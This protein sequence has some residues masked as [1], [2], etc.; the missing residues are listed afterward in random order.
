LRTAIDLG[1]MRIRSRSPSANQSSFSK[2]SARISEKG[3]IKAKRAPAHAQPGRE[4][5]KK[6][7]IGNPKGRVLVCV[8][9]RPLNKVEVKSREPVA[10]KLGRQTVTDVL[11]ESAYRFDY[12]F[13]PKSSTLEIYKKVGRRVVSEAITGFNANIFC[14]GQ[15]ASGKTF[16]TLGNAESPGMVLHAMSDIFHHI[17]KTPERQFLLRVGCI[18]IHNEQVNDL[19]GGRKDLRVEWDDKSKE[20]YMKGLTESFI[21]SSEDF[22]RLILKAEMRR[23]T[24]ATFANER[25]SR[26]HTIYRIRIESRPRQTNENGTRRV[27]CSLL[28]LIDLAGSECISQLPTGKKK[29]ERELKHINRSL[30][31]LSRVIMSLS[32]GKVEHVPY[33]DSKITRI[34]RPALGG[35]SKTLFVCTMGPTETD[36]EVSRNTLRFGSFAQKV[37]NKISV[38]ERVDEKELIKQYKD[39]II[40]MKKKIK[41]YANAIQVTKKTEQENSQLRRRNKDM[42]EKLEKHQRTQR[43]LERRLNLLQRIITESNLM[44]VGS[45][46]GEDTAG[47]SGGGPSG[48]NGDDATGVQVGVKLRVPGQRPSSP[49]PSSSSSYSGTVAHDEEDAQAIRIDLKMMHQREIR[50]SHED[51][52]SETTSF[53]TTSVSSSRLER[54]MLDLTTAFS[55]VRSLSGHSP[56]II[57]D[58]LSPKHKRSPSS[59]SLLSDATSPRSMQALNLATKMNKLFSNPEADGA[60]LMSPRK[61]N[62]KNLDEIDLKDGGTDGPLDMGNMDT[63]QLVEALKAL[64]EENSGL[65]SVTTEIGKAMARLEVETAVVKMSAEKEVQAQRLV[66][67]RNGTQVK[68]K[69]NG[70]R[71]EHEVRLWLDSDDSVLR[72]SAFE[73][74]QSAPEGNPKKGFDEANLCEVA[75]VSELK[76][77]DENEGKE[78]LS[79]TLV[80]TP[81]SWIKVT[82]ATTENYQLWTRGMSPLLPAS[83][84]DSKKRGSS[85]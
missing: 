75:S 28:S 68:I 44:Q 3:K 37:K 47:A 51:S 33:R 12:V 16:T 32:K 40:D 10:W 26:S 14:Y 57:A 43:E 70:W 80:L 84:T 36:R 11:D 1:A 15:T 78:M 35:N 29:L 72:W 65:R 63:Q 8:R 21:R 59:S 25:S 69:R 30:L 64:Q 82:V 9:M 60:A 4:S 45:Q 55:G 49:I 52:A 54:P 74:K 39:L 22:I 17:R 58:V 41:K 48:A 5:V 73:K 61:L 79:F 38:N 81:R 42:V 62:S 56:R 18:E 46:S 77:S 50:G 71:K 2:P 23:K 67:L 7:G 66:A 19:L 27:R 85:R 34:L 20:V 83:T 53:E 6:R 13:G 31:G 76:L 24:A